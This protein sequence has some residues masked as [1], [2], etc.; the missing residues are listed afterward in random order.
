MVLLSYE[1]H[2]CYEVNQLTLSQ[3]G[4]VD[5]KFCIQNGSLNG[6]PIGHVEIGDSEKPRSVAI[7]PIKRLIFWT[8]VG[9]QQ[10]IF[11][12]RIDGA[13][14]IALAEKLEG[15]SAMTVDPQQ[16]L[17]FF[18]HGKIIDMMKIDGQNR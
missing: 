1:Q 11:R 13:E 16:D 7:H 15:V 14:R 17:V 8:D 5:F 10:A 9:S 3:P 4:S 18:A 12:A 6:D 2:Q